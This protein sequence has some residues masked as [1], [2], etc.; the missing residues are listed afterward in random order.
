VVVLPRLPPALVVA[1]VPVSR[2]LAAVM[3]PSVPVAPD[4]V[5]LSPGLMAVTGRSGGRRTDAGF[6][7]HDASREGGGGHE[8]PDE[9]QGERAEPAA[10]GP[11]RKR[12]VVPVV[13]GCRYW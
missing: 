9:D 4:T 12:L 3:V 8:Q 10:D 2:T 5:R 6:L 7:G 11:D 13:V 1:P